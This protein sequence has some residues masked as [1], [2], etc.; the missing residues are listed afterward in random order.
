M[1]SLSAILEC[2]DNTLKNEISRQIDKIYL[3]DNSGY[4]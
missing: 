1:S 2:L 3:G 4:R